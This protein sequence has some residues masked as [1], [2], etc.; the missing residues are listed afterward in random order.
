[1]RK[2]T[3][4]IELKPEY[5]AAIKYYRQQ[6]GWRQY[7]LGMKLN[8]PGSQNSKA[9]RIATWETNGRKTIEKIILTKIAI[10]LDITLEDIFNFIPK[11]INYK[12]EY[13]KLAHENKILKE[14][15]ER[16]QRN[17]ET[18]II[19]EAKKMTN[20]LLEMKVNEYEMKIDILNK[21]LNDQKE[22]IKQY[23][24]KINSLQQHILYE[25]RKN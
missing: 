1:M 6:K 2:R 14:Q 11:E 21:K 7:E 25:R 16:M 17:K 8:I 10:A 15:I 19:E 20:E 18:K 3:E 22:K 24:T 5:S 23:Q 9:S 13:Y 12:E 4:A